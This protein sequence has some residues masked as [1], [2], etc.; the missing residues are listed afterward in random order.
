MTETGI[1]G[2][3]PRVEDSR[4]LTGAGCYSDD[5]VAPAAAWAVL[6]RSPHAHADI[7]ALDSAD[8]ETSSGVLGVFTAADLDADGLG[9]IPCIYPVEGKGGSPTVVPPHPALARD[10][11]HY[12]GEPVALVV[13]ETQDQARDAAE[14]VLVDYR[15]RPSVND[16]ARAQDPDAPQIWPEAPGNVVVDWETGDAQAVARALDQ[17]AHVTT[18]T[19]VNNRVAVNQIEPRAALGE[20][21]AQSG[22]L[23]LTTPSQG[24][25]NM[26]KQLAE[27]IFKLPEDR[28]RVITPDVGGGFGPRGY[29]NSEQIVVLWAARRL[30]RPVRWTAD[31]GECFFADGQGRDHVSTAKLA[32]DADGRFLGLEVSTVANMGA[33]PI[34][35]GP[36]IP[37]E[38]C[39]EMLAGAY[40]IPAIHAEVKCVFTNMAPIDIYRGT[41]RAE[42][43]YLLERLVDAA[44]RELDMTPAELRR[45]N[46]IAPDALP[47]TTVTGLTY[48]SGD[49]PA[50]LEHALG[51]AGWDDAGDRKD[52]AR[53]AGKLLGIGLAYHVASGAG[54]DSEHARLRLD[55][56]GGVTVF[57]GTQ[58]TGQGHETGYAQIVVERLGVPLAVVRIRQ[59]DSD[60]EPVGG[61]T[62]ASRSILMGGLAVRAAA[63]A[64]IEQARGVAA[65]LMQADATDLDF[66]SAAFAVTGADRR[67]TLAEIARAVADDRGAI[68][69]PEGSIGAIETV[70]RGADA[71][72]TFANGCHVCELTVDPE[73][74]RV[75]IQ[76]YVAV[77]DFGTVVNPLLCHGQVH[78]ATAQGI[79]QA[80]LE[81]IVYDAD[82]GQLLT[83]SLLDYCM[84]RADDLP[85]FDVTLVED[86]PCT[87][88]EMGVKGAGE[89]GAI[90]APPAVM[91]ALLDALAPL[92]IDHV[93]M[94]ATPERVWRAIQHAARH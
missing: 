49:F 74:G 94:P 64:F 40:R 87:T 92:G 45:R 54:G 90:A 86:T 75:E 7:V 10:R 1:G 36:Y 29:C 46:F 79:G 47:H 31:R 73:T 48:D 18:L 41:G 69:L 38:L 21:D 4:F 43:I 83:G 81:R 27:H 67:I 28:I 42:A 82:S 14:R 78:G 63:D 72:I 89:S 84:P 80:L 23:T 76:N 68:P 22:R 88:N 57:V 5:V 30:D 12:V 15:D 51:L 66:E 19:L 13:A 62:S 60:L 17:A 39:C 2:S 33:Y 50:I 20:F 8:A 59:G 56:D 93:D 25:H 70:A 9:D 3:V 53:D 32:L 77:D 6:V 52:A 65:Y 71:A 11:V 37:T 35:Y 16:T 61:G 91:N 85:S 58:S 34:H 44:A 26:R 55:D 24:A